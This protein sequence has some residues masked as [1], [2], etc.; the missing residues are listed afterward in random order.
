[1][2][3]NPITPDSP[4]LAFCLQ[5]VVLKV[6]EHLQTCDLREIA[7]DTGISVSNLHR[8]RGGGV[9]SLPVLELLAYYFSPK[10]SRHLGQAESTTPPSEVLP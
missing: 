6:R 2:V 5:F 1:M 7:S 3:A 9:P 4:D 8:L 10:P